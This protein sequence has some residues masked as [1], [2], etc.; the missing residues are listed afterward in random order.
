MPE[1]RSAEGC[2]LR[3]DI[4]PKVLTLSCASEVEWWRLRIEVVREQ[5]TKLS[6]NIDPATIA[7]RLGLLRKWGELALQLSRA[8]HREMQ[9]QAIQKLDAIFGGVL[10]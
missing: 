4:V 6:G 9:A 8:Q 7:L 1:A 5:A 2:K 10:P 3:R